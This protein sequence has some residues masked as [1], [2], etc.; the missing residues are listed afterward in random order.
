[1]I[2]P[3]F[4]GNMVFSYVQK[5]I[6]Y[7]PCSINKYESMVRKYRSHIL[8][9]NTR[10][11]KE[12]PQNTVTRHEE[13]NYSRATSSLLLIKMI[14]QL[15]RTLSSKWCIKKQGLNTEPPQA[16]GAT[17]NKQLTAQPP[18]KIGQQPKPLVGLNAFYWYQTFALDSVAVK[19]K[20]KMFSSH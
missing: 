15:E 19:T 5:M 20:K 3:S 13:D 18:P 11:L 10:Y 12:E 7:V 1:M 14:A 9:I 2:R 16:K 17:I 8:Q 6:S 4:P